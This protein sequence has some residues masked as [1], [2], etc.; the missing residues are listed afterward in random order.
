MSSTSSTFS[1]TLSVK[2][3]SLIN[4]VEILLDMLAQK[5]AE[6]DF[7]EKELERLRLALENLAPSR[8]ALI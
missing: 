1:S 6:T 5:T 2:S 7:Q 4:Q 8:L 3:S